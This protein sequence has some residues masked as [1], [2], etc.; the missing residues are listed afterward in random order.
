MSHLGEENPFTKVIA[1]PGHATGSC[2]VT[3]TL[4]IS[5]VDVTCSDFLVRRSPDGHTNIKVVSG[6]IVTKSG[7]ND[8][9]F[10]DEEAYKGSRGRVWHYQIILRN[11]GK[12]FYSGWVAARGRDPLLFAKT[13]ESTAELPTTND[14]DA[15][16]IV[17]LD[18]PGSI[19]THQR[20]RHQEDGFLAK[21][22]LGIARQIMRLEKTHMK[23]A[24]TQMC[25]FK[26]LLEGAVCTECRDAETGQKTNPS[27]TS[28]YNTGISVGYDK[29]C[30]VY[31]E[32]ITKKTEEI[33]PRPTGEGEDLSLIHI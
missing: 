20:T 23:R 21:Q 11:K 3:W 25:V 17:T 28:C 18:E 30:L 14:I 27:C 32:N 15:C 1:E 12:A 4:D 7:V 29:P 33:K 26:R 2:L 16:N 5:A 22:E 8:Y 24:G 10:S 31:L 9:S 6:V 13:E 19:V